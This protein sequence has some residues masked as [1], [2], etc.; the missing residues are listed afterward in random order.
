MSIKCKGDDFFENYIKCF[1]RLSRSELQKIT[2]HMDMN[3]AYIK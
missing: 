3:K 2:I 1:E